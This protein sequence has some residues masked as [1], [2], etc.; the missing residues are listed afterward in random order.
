MKYYNEAERYK[1]EIGRYQ[2]LVK[3]WDGFKRKIVFLSGDIEFGNTKDKKQFDK[4]FVVVKLTD[5]DSQPASRG[6]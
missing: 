3:E 5:A 4:L 1:K 2:R 6:Y